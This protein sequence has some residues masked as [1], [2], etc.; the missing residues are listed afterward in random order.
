MFGVVISPSTFVEVYF[1]IITLVFLY[2][3]QRRSKFDRQK[4]LPES[5]TIP[6]DIKYYE[7][8]QNKARAYCSF[9]K[10]FFYL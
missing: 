10:Y 7:F 8:K 9:T 1:V 2:L 3:R 4:Q 5:L 6:K